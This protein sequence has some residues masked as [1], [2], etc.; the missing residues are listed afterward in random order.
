MNIKEKLVKLRAAMAEEGMD[1][2]LIPTADFHES[3]YAGEHFAA[4]KYMSGFTGSA[5]TL[6]VGLERAALWTDGRYFIQAEKELSGSGI[7]LMRMGAEDVPSIEKYIEDNIREGGVLG[8]D[9]RVVNASFGLKLKKAISAKNA[10]IKYEKDLVDAIWKDR[11]EIS[12]KPAFFLE[13]KYSGRSS[14]DKLCFVRKTMVEEGADAFVLTSLDDIAWLYNMRGDDIP[15]NPV[16]LSY[17]IIFSDKAVIFL[18]EKV[19][20]DVLR[21]EFAANNVEIKPYSE[22]YGYVK[23]LGGCRRIMLDERKV[24]YAIY[25]NLPDTVEKKDRVNPTILEKAKKNEVEIKNIKNAHIKDGVAMVKF[26]YW[27]KK[28]VGKLKITEMSAS[29]YLEAARREQ[30]GFIEPSFNTIAAYNE[31]AAM[32]HYSA[33]PEHDGELKPEGLFLVDSGGQYYEGTTDITRTIVLGDVKEEWKRD[34]T[35]VLKGHMNLMN[36]KFLY[37]CTGMNLD[38]LCRAPLWNIGIDYRSG[39]GH[40][41]GYL[42]NVH[43]APNGFRWRIVPERNDSA[44]L[45]EGMITTDEPGVYIENSHGIRIE[46]ELLC[47]KDIKNEYG[48]FMCFETVTYAPIDKEAI[49]VKWLEKR[50]IEQINKYHE[51]VFEKLSPHFDGEVLEWL[52]EACAPIES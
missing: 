31:N 29:D 25:S 8:F 15:C 6:L 14:A 1:L 27:L 33:T 7:E 46:N 24:N 19:L 30:E 16:V 5:G 44:V 26:M 36:A 21:K 35:L 32:M 13:E 48:Q 12:A 9:G 3:E 41:I 28:N 23:E 40:G 38:I 11:P 52:G 42:L 10:V 2:Y 18:N 51:L 50:D 39:T 34:Y 22:I 49:D 20:N 43:E 4:R 45:E 17:S 47:K 37:G